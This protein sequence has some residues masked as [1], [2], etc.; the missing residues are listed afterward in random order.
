[1]S[2]IIDYCRP[3][4]Y[5]YKMHNGDKMHKGAVLSLTL[6]ADRTIIL[7]K[8]YNHLIQGF[9]YANVD[10][11]LSSFLHDTGFIYEGKR[12]K[13]FTFSK[14]GYNSLEKTGSFLKLTPP[15]VIH[16]ASPFIQ[17][18]ESLLNKVIR[19]ESLKIGDNHVFLSH[20]Q[21]IEYEPQEQITVRCLSP[22][23]GYR[24]PAGSKR[25][26]YLTPYQED[27]YN[28]LKS[29]LL[30][31]Y[32]LIYG[33]KYKH[34][35]EIEPVKVENFYRKKIVFKGTLIEAWEGIYKVRADEDMIR[36]VFYAGLGAKNSAGFGMVEPC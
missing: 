31:K 13:L 3:Q 11:L 1:M 25:F 32:H 18:T 26:E 35:I 2:Y 20:L 10:R 5:I 8:F 22:I 4:F 6:D 24:T 17:L 12:F 15:L 14:I 21:A 28:L 27:F 34:E 29:N 7:P 23:T 19:K 16:F 36:I 30:K 33:R 9:F